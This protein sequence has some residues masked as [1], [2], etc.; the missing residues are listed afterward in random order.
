[1]MLN[2]NKLMTDLEICFEREECENCPNEVFCKNC[3]LAIGISYDYI[4]WALK[5]RGVLYESN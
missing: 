2:A 4:L 1:M 3:S 5:A